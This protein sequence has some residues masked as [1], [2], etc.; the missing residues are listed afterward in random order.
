M[1]RYPFSLL[2][3]AFLLS[4]TPSYSGTKDTSDIP[5]EIKKRKPAVM[6]VD[7]LFPT[8][9]LDDIDSNFQQTE[10]EK[11]GVKL[12]DVPE[13]NLYSVPDITPENETALL[14]TKEYF[15]Q[16]ENSRVGLDVDERMQLFNSKVLNAMVAENFYYANAWTHESGGDFGIRYTIPSY[17]LRAGND[18]KSLIY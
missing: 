6:T 18:V 10:I 16:T 11:Q 3:L 7:E 12:R 5:D 14:T 9:S 13:L 4:G 15:Y 8:N 1:P 17:K 2:I